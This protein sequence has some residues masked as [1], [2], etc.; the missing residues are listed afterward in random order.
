VYKNTENA[1]K[2]G[3][4]LRR[5]DVYLGKRLRDFRERVGWTLTELGE[6]VGV[7]HQQIHKYENADSKISAAMLFKFAQIFETNPNA[8]FDGFHMIDLDFLKDDTLSLKQKDVINIL[9]IEDSSAD[10]FLIRKAL[11]NCGHQFNFYCAHDGDEVFNVLRRKISIAPFPRPD[12]I[13][14]DLN[15][16]KINGLSI[17]KS[18]KQDREIQDIPIIVLTSS[19]NKMDMINAYKNHASGFISKSFDFNVFQKNL[20]TTINYWVEAVV[21][22]TAS[23]H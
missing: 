10:E 23:Q 1:N 14:L 16:P 7:S 8:F 12:I 18:L 11:E 2:E 5:V 17:L 20:Q 15:L 13:L 4:S 19:L 3:D 21:L 22:P 9:L 6:R